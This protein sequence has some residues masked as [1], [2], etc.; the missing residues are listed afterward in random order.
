MKGIRQ[1]VPRDL[2][3]DYKV[4]LANQWVHWSKLQEHG[5]LGAATQLE[6]SLSNL[7]VAVLMGS[8]HEQQK[9]TESLKSPLDNLCITKLR[10]LP[11]AVAGYSHNTGD[12]R[13]RAGLMSLLKP[14]WNSERKGKQTQAPGD[15]VFPITPLWFKMACVS[16]PAISQR[17]WTLNNGQCLSQKWKHVRRYS[18]VVECLPNMGY[19]QT[20]KQKMGEGDQN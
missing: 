12:K 10:V 14:P 7:E 4:S 16:Y 9:L 11:R 3:K 1:R 2:G 13:K 6:S 8:S 18:S 15:F 20:S 5:W 17:K 19:H